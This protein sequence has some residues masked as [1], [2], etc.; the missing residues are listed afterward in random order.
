M[1]AVMFM[2][3]LL[4]L[5]ALPCIL[6]PEQVWKA[7]NVGDETMDYHLRDVNLVA[8]SEVPS[9]VNGASARSHL[10]SRHRKPSTRN[11][12]PR[13]YGKAHYAST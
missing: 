2:A 8:L 3:L 12:P 5:L 10:P 7:F 1:V 11:R 13:L 9:S 6:M 4:A